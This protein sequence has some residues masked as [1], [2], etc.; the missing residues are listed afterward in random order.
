MGS[1]LFWFG[2]QVLVTGGTGTIGMQIVAELQRRGAFVVAVALDSNEYAR[3]VLP[4]GTVYKR[5]DLRDGKVCLSLVNGMDAVFD[6]TGVK[7]STTTNAQNYS[8]QFVNYMRFQTELMD[9][10]ATVK[11]PAYVFAGSQC[12][13]PQMNVPKQED[14][15]WDALPLQN[16]KF[17]GLVKRIGEVQASTYFEEGSWRGAKILRY[18][19]VYGPGDDFNPTTAQVI[20]ALIAK[21]H[22]LTSVEVNGDGSA[23]RDF[24]Y[25]EDAA[26]WAV[27]AAERLA[28]CTPVNISAGRGISIGEVCKTIQKFVAVEFVFK[29]TEYSGDPVRILDTTRARELLSFYE[30]TSFEDGIRKTIEWY[31][32]NAEVAKLKGKYYGR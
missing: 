12:E 20:P 15:M 16:D 4:P 24:I 5:H 21:S 6:M 9:A 30:R 14:R 3:A 29:P 2:K 26:F 22:M 23:I 10:C 7:G 28:P 25:S 31:R 18:S 1:K 17:A 8:R 27:E 11:T 13:Y 19:N 32:D